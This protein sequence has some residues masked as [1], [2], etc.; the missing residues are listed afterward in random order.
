[1]L[2]VPSASPRESG[3][4]MVPANGVGPPCLL[5]L[6][7]PCSLAACH[8]LMGTGPGTRHVDRQWVVTGLGAKSLLEE[9]NLDQ[10]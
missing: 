6:S 4:Y 1:M 5:A 10:L 3:P 2:L 9:G 7:N 8:Q